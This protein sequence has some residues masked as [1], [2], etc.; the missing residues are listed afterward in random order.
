MFTSDCLLL[1]EQVC[2]LPCVVTV[3]SSGFAWKAGFHFMLNSLIVVI[4]ELTKESSIHGG[5]ATAISC[6]QINGAWW[7]V[8]CFAGIVVIGDIIIEMSS[9]HIDDLAFCFHLMFA[10][11]SILLC[12]SLCLLH[13]HGIIVCD[14]WV[15]PIGRHSSVAQLLELPTIDSSESTLAFGE[16]MQTR[17]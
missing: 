9:S 12:C 13:G 10:S 5:S 14:G 4:G 8:I 6:W 1:S 11:V 15:L 7:L 3:T 2:V 16:T 17:V